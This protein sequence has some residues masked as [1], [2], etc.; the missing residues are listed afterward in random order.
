MR[1]VP[2]RCRLGNPSIRKLRYSLAW[3]R[4]TL[5][6]STR[7]HDMA[8]SSSSILE[9]VDGDLSEEHRAYYDATSAITDSMAL[10]PSMAAETWW[11]FFLP[12]LVSR[13]TPSSFVDAVSFNFT[14]GL[15][16]C[17]VRRLHRR[18]CV[19]R[20][21]NE[22]AGDRGDACAFLGVVNGRSS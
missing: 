21:L 14:V 19:G 3:L 15:D 9:P 12:T 13:L 10:R 17:G 1:H 5:L 7:L 11:G 20:F 16:K 4:R 2:P 18:F 8:S 22:I 6:P